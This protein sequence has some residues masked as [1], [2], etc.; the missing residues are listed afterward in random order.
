M[1]VVAIIARRPELGKVKSRLAADLGVE[2]TLAVY[3]HLLHHTMHEA[4]LSTK[5]CFLFLTGEGV[6]DTEGFSVEE[7]SGND[8]GARMENAIGRCL[9]L[10]AHKVVLIGSDIAEMSTNILQKAFHALDTVDIVLGPSID[11]GYYLIGMKRLWPL[12]HDIEWSTN[13]V[14]SATMSKASFVNA[15]VH[16]LEELNDIDTL[17]DLQ[18]STL[19][20]KLDHL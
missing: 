3:T 20:N 15:T 2:K 10:G 4:A 14:L 7:Q 8:L 12:F 16:L 11:G 9:Q 19:W 1:D 17:H 5:H 6:L 18:Q 13:K